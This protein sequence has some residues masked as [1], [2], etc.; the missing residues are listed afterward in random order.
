[1]TTTAILAVITALAGGGGI[2]ALV[3][4]FANRGKSGAEEAEIW[5]RASIARLKSMYEQL[6]QMEV[7][8]QSL[9]Q[10]LET[11]RQSYLSQV[12]ELRRCTET[13]RQAT[14]ILR[15]HGIEWSPTI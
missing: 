11:Q 7:K 12:E 10:E 5:T 3:Q 13:V 1:M 4:W 15:E 9:N 8:I 6:E 2:A 14:A